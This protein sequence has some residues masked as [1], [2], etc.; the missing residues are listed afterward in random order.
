MIHSRVTYLLPILWSFGI[1]LPIVCT[2]S[3]P[4]LFCDEGNESYSHAEFK[5]DCET[6]GKLVTTIPGPLNNS[7]PW[8]WNPECEKWWIKRGVCYFSF[9]PSSSLSSEVWDIVL[10]DLRAI[11]QDCV[12][13]SGAGGFREREDRV[14]VMVFIEQEKDFEHPSP[15][16][17]SN[18]QRVRK[19]DRKKLRILPSISE[20]PLKRRRLPRGYV[21]D[22]SSIFTRGKVFGSTSRGFNIPVY[23][24]PHARFEDL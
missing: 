21:S 11:Q 9:M 8:K 17:T 23:P 2:Q 15:S 20:E 1:L 7:S 24:R 5:K 10:E 18:Q 19:P 12:D 22:H 16:P 3:P 13:Q 6:L 14:D 4:E